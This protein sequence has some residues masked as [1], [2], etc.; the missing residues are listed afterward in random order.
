MDFFKE[1]CL[2]YEDVQIFTNNFTTPIWSHRY[3]LKKQFPTFEV[4]LYKTFDKRTYTLH[5][6]FHSLSEAEQYT[7]AVESLYPDS[8]AEP[9][10]Q[11]Y[12][13]GLL[14]PPDI[15]LQTGIE[16]KKGHVTYQFTKAKD[17]CK[18]LNLLE[19]GIS[20]AKGN[21]S[22]TRGWTVTSIQTSV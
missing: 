18:M 4:V 1:R 16:L 13:D 20:K 21:G 17:A 7:A 8:K 14:L 15:R 3:E 22:K 6:M 19:S 11:A 10:F 12:H 5:R 2:L 9:V